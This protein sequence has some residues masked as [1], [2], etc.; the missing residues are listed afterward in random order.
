M[1]R[2]IMAFV[3]HNLY[4]VATLV[5]V[6]V[7]LGWYVSCKRGT[8]DQ[9]YFLAA[10]LIVGWLLSIHFTHCFRS[11][12]MFGLVLKQS[13]YTDSVYFVLIYGLVT[14]GFSCAI[15]V[16]YYDFPEMLAEQPS[17]LDTMYQA[18]KVGYTPTC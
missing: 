15:N 12:H 4:I 18:L 10:T 3:L 17:P 5:L 2:D 14:A 11:M 8:H 6:V 7:V 1:A 9:I 13:L 16:L